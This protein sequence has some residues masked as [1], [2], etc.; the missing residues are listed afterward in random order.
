MG[1]QLRLTGKRVL[2]LNGQLVLDVVTRFE[3]TIINLDSSNQKQDHSLL[4]FNLNIH[5]ST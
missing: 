4:P 5:P 2:A 1:Y 3:T